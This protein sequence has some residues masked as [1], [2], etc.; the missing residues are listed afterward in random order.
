MTN[1]HIETERLVLREWEPTD[2]AAV[3]EYASDPEN[4]KYMVWGPNSEEQ[5]REFLRDV[6]RRREEH[7]RFVI[8]LAVC[9]KE[10]GKL[11]GGCSLEYESQAPGE[12]QLGYVLNKQYWGKGYG[13]EAASALVEW[14][15][16]ACGLKVL[17][18]TCNAENRASARLMEKIG[19]EP[20]ALWPK[21]IRLRSGKWRDT[22]V[23]RMDLHAVN[24]NGK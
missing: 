6:A 13:P 16:V 11:I 2:F 12:A 22:L 20:F 18:C 21:H 19:M 10:D 3:H 15:R 8:S 14:A 5:T 1:I 24:Q 9:L 17:W 23:Y 4:V 7:P